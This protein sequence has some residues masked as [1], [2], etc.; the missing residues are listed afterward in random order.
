VYAD[1]QRRIESRLDH[2]LP[3]M[4]PEAAA[5]AASQG[6]LTRRRKSGTHSLRVV[7]GWCVFFNHGCVLHAHGAAEGNKFLYKP[8]ACATFPLEQ[9]PTRGWYVRQKGVLGEVWNLFCLDPAQTQTP[10]ATSLRE[11]IALIAPSASPPR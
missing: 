7:A 6:I 5:I 9:H 1:E 2:L 8:W 3:L 11:E 4:R 10:A